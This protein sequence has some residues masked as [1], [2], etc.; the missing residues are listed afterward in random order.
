[1]NYRMRVAIPCLFLVL[2]ACSPPKRDYTVEQI[3]AETDFEQLM[4]AQATIADPRFK[5]AGQLDAA[6]MTKD[7]FAQF[8]DM[9]TRLGAASARLKA[10]SQGAEFDAFADDQAKKSSDLVKFAQAGDGSKTLKAARSIKKTC[11]AC[12]AQYR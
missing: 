4:Y 1:M 6:K 7:D 3:K 8:I 11:A 5:L 12:H 9:G 2:I 10:F